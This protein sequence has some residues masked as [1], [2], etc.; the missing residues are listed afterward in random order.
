MFLAIRVQVGECVWVIYYTRRSQTVPWIRFRVKVVVS[1]I[2]RLYTVAVRVAGYLARG[3]LL[4]EFAVLIQ[5]QDNHLSGA[6]RR[7]ER[8]REKSRLPALYKLP[9]MRVPLSISEAE[10]RAIV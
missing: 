5:T 1:P 2:C 6:H 4:T 3:G 10:R 9:S 7:G 8:G